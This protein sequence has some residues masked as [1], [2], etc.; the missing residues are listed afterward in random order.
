MDRP[1]RYADTN[2][3]EKDRVRSIWPYRDW[4]INAF[5]A[6]MPFDQFTIEQLAGDLLP[7]ATMGQR[8]ATG[9][10]R[11]TML[12]EE[13]GIDPLEFRYYAMADRV[14]TTSTVWL[15]LTMGYAQCHTH[16]YDPIPHREYYQFMALLNNADEPEMPGGPNPRSPASDE[17]SK[18]RYPGLSRICRADFPAYSRPDSTSGSRA[19]QPGFSTGM[20]SGRLRRSRIYPS[21]AWRRTR[22]FSQAATRA[23]EISTHYASSLH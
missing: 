13:G 16:K 3:Y 5:N 22:R 12:N 17:K 18:A 9:F 21:S 1:A 20:C 15:G 14:N 23:S 6:D 2:G 4:V 10:H 7:G 11:N 8:I 19:R